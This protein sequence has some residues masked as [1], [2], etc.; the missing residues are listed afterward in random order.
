M[1]TADSFSKA[2]KQALRIFSS[3]WVL[4][5]LRIFNFEAGTNF[6]EYG[7]K[8]PSFWLLSFFKTLDSSWSILDFIDKTSFEIWYLL[9]NNFQYPNRFFSSALALGINSSIMPTYFGSDLNSSRFLSA[10]CILL[11]TEW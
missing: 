2:K 11:S 5:K 4:T 10:S 9:K 1:K 8:Y 7:S 6:R 3:S